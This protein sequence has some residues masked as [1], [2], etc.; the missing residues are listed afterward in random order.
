ME[1]STPT[2]PSPQQLWQAALGELQMLVAGPVYENFLKGT[3]GARRHN[4][5]L[6]VAAPSDFVLGWLDTKLR[7]LLTQTVQRLSGEPLTLEFTVPTNAECGMRNAESPTSSEP[8]TQP[9]V[10]PESAIRSPQSAIRLNP[11]YTF[12]TFVVGK[13]NQLAHGAAQAVAAAPGQHYNP[14]F[15][16]GGV[17]LG[18]THLLHAIGHEALTQGLTVV[19]VSSEQFTNDFVNS[20]RDRRSEEFRA[21]YR[22]PDVLL[23]DDIQFIAGKEQTQEEFFHTFNDLHSARRQVVITSDRA[24]KSISLLEDRLVSRFEWGLI[25]DVQ[26]PDYETRLAILR[27]KAEEQRVAVPGAVLDFIAQRVSE[28]IREL[29]GSFNRVVAF[30]RLTGE[31]FSLALAARALGEIAPAPRRRIPA[32]EQII[33]AVADYYGLPPQKLA[34]QARDRHL[35]HARHVAMYLLR[36]DGMRPLTEIGKLLGKRDHTTVMH[37]TEKIERSLPTDP[38]LRSELAAIRAQVT[39]G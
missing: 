13:S 26:P 12:K 11:A 25:A 24:P 34:G 10:A 33:D 2:Q 31:D 19:Y 5:T 27:T 21:R 35:V 22:T 9:V 1:T 32:P 4:G 36:H 28:N 17:G 6:T 23:I 3:I 20:I 8:Q 30:A 39:G 14:L 7:P 15:L 18:K 29:E 38:E 16:Y 37:G